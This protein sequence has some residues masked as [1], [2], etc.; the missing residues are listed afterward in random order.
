MKGYRA[1]RF[2]TESIHVPLMALKPPYRGADDVMFV[3]P[4]LALRAPATPGARFFM[5]ARPGGHTGKREGA[6]AL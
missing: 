1:Q 4:C 5:L 6:S 2:C 3:I